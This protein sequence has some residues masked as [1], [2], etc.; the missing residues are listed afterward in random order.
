MK[1]IKKAATILGFEVTVRHDGPNRYHVVIEPPFG[2]E[3][4]P[5]WNEPGR[6]KFILAYGRTGKIIPA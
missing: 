1:K 5:Y 6:F 3:L 2:W 4:Y